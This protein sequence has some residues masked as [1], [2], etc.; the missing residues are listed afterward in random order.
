M[1][2]EQP[3]YIGV[4]LGTNSVKICIID[5]KNKS[6]RVIEEKSAPH[7]AWIT[8]KNANESRQ[9]AEK[10]IFT[11]IHL[12]KSLQEHIKGQFDQVN[13]CVTGQMHGIVLWNAESLVQGKFRCS[14]LITWMDSSIPT[15]FILKLPKWREGE[16]HQGYGMVTLAWLHKNH[17]IDIHWNRCGTIMDMFNCYITQKDECIMGIQT[18]FSWG[19]C[20]YFGRWTVQDGI[21][22]MSLLPRISFRLRRIGVVGLADMGI[23]RKA[24]VFVSTGDLQCTAAPVHSGCA[25]LNLGTSA[26]LFCRMSYGYRIE[27]LPSSSLIEIP[28]FNQQ[29]LLVAASLNGGNSI[30]LLAKAKPREKPTCSVQP[31]FYGERD[32]NIL[33]A[34]TNLQPKTSISDV[35]TL[36]A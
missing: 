36:E 12:L 1:M 33:A 32:A 15:E 9:D 26:Q 10:I 16:L 23:A 27:K 2:A 7:N 29:R 19:Y 4:D 34:I 24:N 8:P 30:E 31:T 11:A 28:F 6:F 22:P 21:V 18:A 25:G 5:K 3:L 35:N 13:I 20:D 14:S 17:L